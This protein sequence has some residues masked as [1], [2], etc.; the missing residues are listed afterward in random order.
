MSNGMPSTPAC[1]ATR[2]LFAEDQP[3]AYDL[4]ELGRYYKAY[5]ALMDHWRTV[6]P[7]ERMLEVRYEDLVEDLE[8]QARRLVA[9]CGVE[10]DKRCLAFHETKRPVHT[11]SLVQVRKSIYASSVGRSRFYGSRLKPLMD[12][13]EIDGTPSKGAAGRNRRASKAAVEP[14]RDGGKPVRPASSGKSEG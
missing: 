11:A 5:E 10:W 12:A 7:P 2:C 9:H 3:F 1:P 6:L 8:G 4:G 14:A 13:L